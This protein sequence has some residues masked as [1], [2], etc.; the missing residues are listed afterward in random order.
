MLDKYSFNRGRMSTFEKLV[1][2]RKKSGISQ[3]EMFKKLDLTKTTMSRYENGSR[4]IS[5]ELQDKYA[6]YLGYEIKLMV[7]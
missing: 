2:L 5:A 6:E 3:K 1:E 4:K 7:K